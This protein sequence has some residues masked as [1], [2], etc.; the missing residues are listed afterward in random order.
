[1]LDAFKDNGLIEMHCPEC[2]AISQLRLSSGLCKFLT[3]C[4]NCKSEL[5]V[6]PVIHTSRAN[7]VA[8]E[9]QIRVIPS[10]KKEQQPNLKVV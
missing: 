1:M 2:G 7:W 9:L 3:D 10:E 4:F 8:L 5:I 6:K